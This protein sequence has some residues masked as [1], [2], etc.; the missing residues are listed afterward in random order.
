MGS[1]F[2][3]DRTAPSNVSWQNNVGDCSK[4]PGAMLTSLQ[5]RHYEHD[6]VSNRRRLDCL[7]NRFFRHRSR[8]TSKLCVTGLC[9]GNSPVTGEFP[10]QRTND[11]ENVSI[12]WRHHVEQVMAIFWDDG[13]NAMH[14]G[15][16]WWSIAS[17][18]SSTPM[19]HSD[20]T[21]HRSSWPTLVRV[22]ACRL[23]GA[24]SLPELW[25]L[26]IDWT[27][28]NKLNS[29]EIRIKTQ[30]ISFSPEASF[31]LRILSLPA[32][33]CLSVRVSTPCSSAP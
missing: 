1:A 3:D 4:G 10:T 5:W 33:V 11:A 19:W 30:W 22:M 9:E 29:S 12:W 18:T 8:K 16:L 15:I 6:G 26:I 2:P 21:W 14:C 31:G 32:C 13:E 7:L 25:W 20:A 23:F 28:K 17:C 27:T 24:K